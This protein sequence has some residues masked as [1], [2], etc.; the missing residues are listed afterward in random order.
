MGQ[1]IYCNGDFVLVYLDLLLKSIHLLQFVLYTIIMEFYDFRYLSKF[2]LFVEFLKT[3]SL[4]KGTIN[5]GNTTTVFAFQVTFL[6]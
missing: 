5:L 1:H 3:C 4:D 2:H 6:L